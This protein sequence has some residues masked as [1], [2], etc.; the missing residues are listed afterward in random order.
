MIFYVI[1]LYLYCQSISTRSKYI[2]DSLHLTHT[3]TY[4]TK[5][6]LLLQYSGKDETTKQA[7]FMRVKFFH[8]LYMTITFI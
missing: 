6:S 3:L 4:D 7:L 1:P 8:V 5:Y 2:P